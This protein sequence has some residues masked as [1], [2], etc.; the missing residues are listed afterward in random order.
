MARY[1][2]RK[3]PTLS[4]ADA[5]S[6]VSGSH[7]RVGTVRLTENELVGSPGR[8]CQGLYTLDRDV[9]LSQDLVLHIDPRY[10]AARD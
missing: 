8:E 1:C 6:H 5:C 7:G 9:P 4:T 10:H 3:H 2:K